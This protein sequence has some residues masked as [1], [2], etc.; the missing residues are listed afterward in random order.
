MGAVRADEHQKGT[1]V[2]AARKHHSCAILIKG[3]P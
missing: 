1:A 2:V 3:V